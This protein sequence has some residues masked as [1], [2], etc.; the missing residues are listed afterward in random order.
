[1]L[2]FDIQSALADEPRRLL[3]S[4][5]ERFRNATRRR[6]EGR[7][8]AGAINLTSLALT[9][10]SNDTALTASTLEAYRL[11]VPLAAQAQLD[12]DSVFACLYGLETLSQVI[13][14]SV[15]SFA[16]IV[17]NDEP[18]FHHRGL[19]IDTARHFLPLSIIRLI[20]DGM[21]MEK[22]NVFHWHLTDSESWPFQL[23]TFP[24][25]SL[26]GAYTPRLTY[27][28]SDVRAIVEYAYDRGIRV[29][30]E[31]DSP[32]H[33]A[34]V[35]AA[36]PDWFACQPADGL[37]AHWLL[38]DPSN[39]DV[40]TFMDG[41]MHVLNQTFMSDTWHLGGDEVGLNYFDW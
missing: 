37:T 14:E 33:M 38:L 25:I 30:P 19:M 28:T 32:A 39:E 4:G 31:I 29:I 7:D 5:I 21:A 6:S 24:N 15:I 13:E 1:M 8:D 9:V 2:D 40:F 20:I 22:L 12:C 36:Y 10:T 41:V 16:P 11:R 23:P 35:N 34:S 27:T 17:V 3:Q 18:R 26:L